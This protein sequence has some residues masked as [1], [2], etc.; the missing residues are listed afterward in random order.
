MTI[1]DTSLYIGAAEK[2]EVRK[3]LEAIAK[4]DLFFPAVLLKKK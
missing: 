4:K 3:L 2:G 1:V